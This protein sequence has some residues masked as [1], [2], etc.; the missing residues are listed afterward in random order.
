MTGFASL[1]REAEG[2][3]IGVTIRAVNH[4]FL[5]LQVRLPPAL[6]PLEPQV[7]A[8]VQRRVGRGRVEVTVTAASLQPPPMEVRVD[9]ALVAALVAAANRLRAAGLGGE[10][11][12]ADV[13]R[14]PQVV[15]L[16]EAPASPAAEAA[17]AAALD[18]ALREA[19]DQLDEMRRR[20]G[21]FLAADLEARRARLLSLVDEIERTAA[22]ARELRQAQLAARLQELEARAVDPGVLAQE[23][24][25]YV[26]RADI[27]E[28]IVR[29]RAHLEHWRLLVEGPE[30]CGRR[31]G[32][33]LQEMQREINT[34]G[35]KTEGAVASLVV[36]V[37]AE[38]ER[39]Q[40]QAQN[41]E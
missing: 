9:E 40:E 1:A 37:K 27:N 34:I 39:A 17:P 35:A 23:I 20:E 16:L 32:F 26:A 10:L 15:S 8:E 28:E 18:G 12:V 24:V 33:L 22:A 6:A 31:L 19:L 4:R 41:V 36:E 30:P 21:T 7:R 29:L 2:W 11:T 38:L 13:L 14:F 25:R 3:T 5:D